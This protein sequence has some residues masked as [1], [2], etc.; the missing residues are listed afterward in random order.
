MKE[1]ICT[2]PI[3]DVFSPKDGCPIC[4]LHDMLEQNYVDYIL[5]AAMME[6]DVRM[7]T[8]EK[9]FCTK[10]FHMMVGK[11]RRLQNA[12]ILETHLEKIINE[13]LPENAKG[14]PDKKNIEALENL[15]RSCY[16]CDKISWGMEHMFRT[17]FSSF[18]SD[19]TFRELYEAQPFICLP[20]YTM[21]IRS[22]SAKGGLKGAELSEFY[23]STARLSGGYLK[24]LKG[25]VS[26]YCK[27][28]DYRNRGEDWGNSR[29]S[30][31]RSVEFLTSERP[32]YIEKP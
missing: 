12:L 3:N 13:L 14:K 30:I 22:A 17:I 7:E 28:Y 15:Q 9:G 5:G 21:L 31:E 20:H 8:N 11:G 1:T 6:P 10:H 26:H 4:R 25:D 2:I 18:A 24:E 29:D 27:M 23:K 19:P 16:V 32:E